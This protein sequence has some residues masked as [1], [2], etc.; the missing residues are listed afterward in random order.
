MWTEYAVNPELTEYLLYP[1]MLATAELTWTPL[2]K[3]DFDSFTHRLYNQ[4]VRLDEHHVNYYIPVPEGPKAD[5]LVILHEDSLAFS[6]SL[7]LPMRYTTDG[8]VP[9]AESATYESPL[10]VTGN[11]TIRIAS[12]LPSGKL[13]AVRTVEVEK[14]SLAPAVDKKVAAGIFVERAEGDFYFVKDVKNAKWGEK[15]IV[16]D[17]TTNKGKVKLEDKGAF[18]YSGFFRVPEDGVY[19]ISTEMDELQIDGNVV[20][21][22]DGK[23]MRHTHNRT[24]L[25]LAKGYHEFRL[26]FIN[27]N[28][29]GF[30]RIWNNPGFVISQ[31]EGDFHQPEG[32]SH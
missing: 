32:L 16:A 28:I 25:A 11:E 3:K 23:L 27:N 22:N 29:G 24:S 2:E 6:N 15:Q 13:S 9:T 26:L 30:P 4:Y 5:K 8:S 21:S 10:V 17:F 14:G 31:E 12:V 19:Y 18:C 20:L 1:R 7:N